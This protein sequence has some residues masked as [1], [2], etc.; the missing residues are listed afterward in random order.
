MLTIVLPT[1]RVMKDAI[2]VMDKTGIP[3]QK[4]KNKGRKLIVE[5]GH[6]RFIFAKPMDVPLHISHG[7]ADLG[8]VGS[9][10]MKEL[11]VPLIELADTG[12]G[13]CRI[14]VA[15]PPHLEKRFNGHESGLMWLTVATK[16]PNIADRYF[17][18]RGVQV[19]ILNLHGSI[20]LAPVI[21]L[22]DCILD[23]VQTGST[24]R[25]NNL[26][27][28]ENVIPVS[29][30]LAANKKSTQFKWRDISDIVKKIKEFREVENHWGNHMK[31]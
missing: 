7:T 3:V 28:L 30:Y 20:E 6:Y 1:G 9:D 21:G 11:E 26:K 19:K 27:I 12:K 5:D 17:S 23:I 15:G 10:V 22:S 13:K 16:Y 8:F 14:V 18:S 2:D 25:A 31:E 29:L 24:L 4:I